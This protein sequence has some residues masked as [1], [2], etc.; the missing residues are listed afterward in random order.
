MHL[1][2]QMQYKASF[3]LTALGKFLVSFTALIGLYF[4]FARFKEVEGFT[5]HQVLLCFATMLF[6]S[7]LAECLGH[8]FGVFPQMLGNGEF[9][10]V[11]VRPMGEIFQVLALKMDFTRVGRILQAVVVLGYAM[12]AS[13]VTW[14]P[15]KILTLFV[16]IS[17]GTLIFFG[18]FLIY[19][20]L[21]FFTI[22]GLEFMNILTYGSQEFGRYPFSVYGRRVLRFFTYVVPLALFQYYPFLYLIG[23]EESQFYMLTPLLGLLFLVPCCVFWRFGVSRYKSTGS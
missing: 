2:S 10:R 6:T 1:K 22:E 21:T 17:C 9:D 18:L 12:S 23:R 8:G 20:A 5:Y 14:T 7:S 11:L 3:F 4:M 16:M 19:A 13:E 15:D